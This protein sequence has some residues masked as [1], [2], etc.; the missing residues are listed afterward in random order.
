MKKIVLLIISLLLVTGCSSQYHLVINE[1]L[2]VNEEAILTGT[3]DFFANYYKTTKKK[4]IKSMVEEYSTILDENGYTY[5][6]VE[7]EKPY[8]V[9]S[10][11]YHDLNE[12][13]KTSILFNDYFD[14]VNYVE[15][16][17]M[18]KIETVGFNPNNPDDP[19][20]FNVKELK[21]SITCPY[22]VKNHNATKVNKA[23][24]TYYFE[25]NEESDYKILLEFNTSKKYNSHEESIIIIISCL[26]L[27]CLCWII[28]Y[29]INKK[30]K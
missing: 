29:I 12:Y 1:D 8:A 22:K 16:G 23:T 28:I 19:N 25:L 24:N 26:G 3:N 6:I 2:T 17:E 5:N 4:V 21:I 18:K 7:E 10:K 11:K 9:V 20:R 15:N 30:K 13:T 14:E 27:I